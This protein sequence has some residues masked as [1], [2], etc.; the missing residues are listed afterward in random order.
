M[1]DE[2]PAAIAAALVARQAVGLPLPGNLD[3]LAELGVPDEVVDALR[4]LLLA[5]GQVVDGEARLVRLWIALLARSPAAA[6][7][8]SD[9]RDAL[10]GNVLAGR[11]DREWRQVLAGEFARISADAWYSPVAMGRV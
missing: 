10:K 5:S 11:E 8:G 4:E 1:P 2:T 3:Q 6:A 7:L 9:E